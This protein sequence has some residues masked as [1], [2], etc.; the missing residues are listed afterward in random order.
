[1]TLK[2]LLEVIQL[3]HPGKGE[4]LIRQGLNRAQDNFSAKTGML[5]ATGTDDT[6]A[7]Q[8]RY[9][10]HSEMLDV[11]RVELDNEQIPKLLGQPPVGDVDNTAGDG[12]SGTAISMKDKKDKYAWY[13]DGFVINLVEK[14]ASTTD[15]NFNWQTV[16]TNDLELRLYYTRKANKFT[17][18]DLTLVSELPSQFHEALAMKVISDFYKLPGETFNLQVA[19]F[20]DKEF[21]RE[22]REGKKYAR[23]DHQRTGYI[24]P[25]GY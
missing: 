7:G 11:Y 12:I 8:R 25:W 5:K 3:H 17:A 14:C 2:E 13:I 21:E 20:F 24:Q 9:T 23:R 22:V 16:S 6:V 15:Y 4:T 10:L 1:M 19:G 18:N